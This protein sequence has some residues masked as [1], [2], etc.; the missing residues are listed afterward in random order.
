MRSDRRSLFPVGLVVLGGEEVGVNLDVGDGAFGRQR[1]VTIAASEAVDGDSGIRGCTAGGRRHL[2]ELTEEVVW[3]VSKGLETLAGNSLGRTA[4]SCGTC[5]GW[6][7]IVGYG[8]EG[9]V[10][11]LGV[12]SDG[13]LCEAGGS[14]GDVGG[15]SAVAHDAG[16][17]GAGRD[18]RPC[19]GVSGEDESAQGHKR[20]DE[21]DAEVIH[22]LL[23]IWRNQPGLSFGPVSVITQ[24][25]YCWFLL[26]C[27][28]SPPAH[29]KPGPSTRRSRWHEASGTKQ[30]R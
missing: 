15:G 4:R 14:D 5:G 27:L 12:E 30:S 23:E 20:R 16:Q 7:S 22:G 26:Q 6:A 9:S 11:F 3:V 21:R 1:G 28:S 10:D 24:G 19:G 25:R 17:W 29:F 2:L 8:I 18:S 13:E